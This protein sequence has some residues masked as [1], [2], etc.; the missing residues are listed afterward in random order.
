MCPPLFDFINHKIYAFAVQIRR[1]PRKYVSIILK[2]IKSST[3]LVAIF[4]RLRHQIAATTAI[5][6]RLI[7]EETIKLKNAR[8]R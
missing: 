3:P 8:P 1:S 7:H 2:F 5:I 6:S 4:H